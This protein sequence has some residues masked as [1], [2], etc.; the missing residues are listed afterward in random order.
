MTI[1]AITPLWDM[2]EDREWKPGKA[3]GTELVMRFQQQIEPRI[4]YPLGG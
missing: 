2:K 1:T 3:K 4:F